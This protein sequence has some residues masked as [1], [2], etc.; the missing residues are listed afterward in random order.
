MARTTHRDRYDAAPRPFG[1]ALWL[2]ATVAIAAVILSMMG[3]TLAVADGAAR[4][5][6]FTGQDLIALA[7]PSPTVPAAPSANVGTT[8]QSS[9][10]VESL[11]NVESLNDREPLNVDEQLIEAPRLAESAVDTDPGSPKTGD[12]FEINKQ[13]R[14]ALDTI[15][16]PWRELLPGWTIS[17]LPEKDG[18]YGLTIVPEKRIEI[19]VR[20]EQSTTFL[21]HVLAHEL[22]HAVDVTLNTGPDRRSWE[23]VRGIDSDPWWPGSGATDFS[24]GAG[25]FA[26][27]FAAWQVG[28][29]SFRS[30]LAD[31]PSAEQ[32]KLLAELSA[33]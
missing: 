11:N 30:K 12:A 9:N 3:E 19:Y 17:F 32:I 13:G 4:Q 16:Y 21:A 8:Q 27:S 22:G 25:D 28:T 5:N 31:A 1:Q 18:L 7:Q 33:D 26:E 14:A 15:S 10:D 24:T 23:A 29:Q 20:E 2:L 6:S